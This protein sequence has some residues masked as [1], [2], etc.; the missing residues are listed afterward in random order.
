MSG[1]AELLSP[2]TARLKATKATA[3]DQQWTREP[4]ESVLIACLSHA[5]CFLFDLHDYIDSLTLVLL[6]LLNGR[7]MPWTARRCYT[8]LSHSLWRHLA[9]SDK[10]LKALLSLNC[11]PNRAVS[12]HRRRWRPSHTIAGSQGKSAFWQ[13]FPSCLRR[14]FDFATLVIV[15]IIFASLVGLSCRSSFHLFAA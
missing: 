9:T 8:L 5:N 12:G 1:S 15:S 2:A 3:L 11:A 14:P 6:P 10:H 7:N 13:L 4:S